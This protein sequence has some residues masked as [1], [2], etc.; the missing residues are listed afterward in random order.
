MYSMPDHDGA[1]LDWLANFEIAVRYTFDQ[2]TVLQTTT[3][4][5]LNADG[6]RLD[7]AVLR[8][9]LQPK[10]TLYREKY[11]AALSTCSATLRRQPWN[12]LMWLQDSLDFKNS[13]IWVDSW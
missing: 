5:W 1:S 2:F 6:H 12:Y 4:F 11:K 9:V 10:R 13:H 8:S 7:V 3:G